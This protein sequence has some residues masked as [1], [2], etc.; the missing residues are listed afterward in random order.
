M[1]RLLFTGAVCH[2]AGFFH[3]L[4]HITNAFEHYKPSNAHT[5]ISIPLM[6]ALIRRTPHGSAKPQSNISIV[7]SEWWRYHNSIVLWII[8]HILL[9]YSCFVS[10]L[11]LVVVLFYCDAV[12]RRYRCIDFD[13]LWKSDGNWWW[14]QWSDSQMKNTNYTHMHN[15]HL[16][17]C[18][19]QRRCENRNNSSRTGLIDDFFY[20]FCLFQLSSYISIA[21]S[22]S[23]LS[24]IVPLLSTLYER[25]IECVNCVHKISNSRCC[26]HKKLTRTTIITHIHIHMPKMSLSV[27]PY[28]SLAASH[29]IMAK[30]NYTNIDHT[31]YSQCTSRQQCL[32]FSIQIQI[33]WTI[34]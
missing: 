11:I 32:F 4:L 8:F 15:R 10:G 25:S 21:R 16:W 29:T 34:M 3:R 33:A 5:T 14:S 2:L 30:C 9:A 6:G 1:T 13:S 31:S 17:M 20:Y 27:S 26:I 7:Y 28:A 24:K 23:V 19:D 12:F 22:D 18:T